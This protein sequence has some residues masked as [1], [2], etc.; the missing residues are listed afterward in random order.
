MYNIFL[1]ENNRRD[2]TWK[3][4]KWGTA[5]L[6]RNTSSLLYTHS[7]KFYEDNCIMNSERVMENYT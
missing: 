4:K 5:I 3:L 6:A 1:G 2:I 7:Y